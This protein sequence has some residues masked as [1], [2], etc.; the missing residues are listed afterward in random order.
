MSNPPFNGLEPLTPLCAMGALYIV[1]LVV[2]RLYLLPT[3]DAIR[4]RSKLKT[5]VHK[6]AFSLEQMLFYGLLLA[7]FLFG[8]LVL[9]GEGLFDIFFD[10]DANDPEV[11]Q[12]VFVGLLLL[13]GAV[14]L[15][16]MMQ[17]R[18]KPKP[19]GGKK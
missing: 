5:Y 9:F 19:K 6:A 11:Q 16:Y 13:V 7:A 14:L 2:L 10:L 18:S 12:W 3:I 1:G 17:G 4:K 15:R 8:V